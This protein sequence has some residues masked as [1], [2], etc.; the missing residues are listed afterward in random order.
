MRAPVL[1]SAPVHA[2]WKDL[3]GH[4]QLKKPDQRPSWPG[5]FNPNDGKPQAGAVNARELSRACA[6]LDNPLNTMET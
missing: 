3:F 6:C 1:G 2:G 5:F 4:A